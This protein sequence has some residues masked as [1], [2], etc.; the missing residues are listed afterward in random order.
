MSGEDLGLGKII[1]TPKERDAIHIAVVPCI[2]LT[3]VIPGAPVK[4]INGKAISCDHIEDADGIVDP[5]LD[6]EAH[7]KWH[8]E[9]GT[10]V[11]VYLKPGS[12]TSLRHDWT[13]PAFDKGRRRVVHEDDV[14]V[15]EAAAMLG[16]DVENLMGAAKVYDTSGKHFTLGFDT[17]DFS[18]EHMNAI[19]RTYA[20]RKDATPEETEKLTKN[21][22]F[23]S[24]AC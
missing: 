22:H 21:G 3:D 23:F 6:R 2:T 24:C 14:M 4:I 9:P 15:E 16:I 10:T 17:P 19:W 1:T 8:Y 11:W 13:H 7:G 18:D 20:R 12:I 5:F